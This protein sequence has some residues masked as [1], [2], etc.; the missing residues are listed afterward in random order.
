MAQGINKIGSE[1]SGL[2]L[3]IKE[4]KGDAKRS[5]EG[6]KQR[7]EALRP[8]LQEIWDAFDRGETV[9]GQST[10]KQWCEEFAF[11]SQRNIQYI[12][13]GGNTN[14]P[15]AKRFAT[16]KIGGVYAVDRGEANG[17]KQ[18]FELLESS[19]H[20]GLWL[21][22]VEEPKPAPVAKVKKL[23]AAETAE[24]IQ[25]FESDYQDQQESDGSRKWVNHYE[26][27][28]LLTAEAHPEWRAQQIRTELNRIERMKNLIKF[29]T[30]RKAE[31]KRK[32]KIACEQDRVKRA[33]A[34]AERANQV[35]VVLADCPSA[36]VLEE[37]DANQKI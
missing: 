24:A 10:K 36:E 25:Q 19:L 12:L 8:L 5:R 29:G 35:T 32:A 34:E 30:K 4:A 9:N 22:L 14:R 27:D 21:K 28:F 3:Q 7:I 20:D 1:A 15:D 18:K 6:N 31:D 17:G 13:K 23:T 37:D 2:L 33:A 16:L 26:K 11:T